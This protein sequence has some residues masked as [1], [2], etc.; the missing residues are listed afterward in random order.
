MEK[1]RLDKWLWACRFYKSRT[2]ASEACKN[3]KIS[4]RSIPL[5]AAHFVSVGDLLEIRKNGFQFL[6]LIQKIIEKRVGA[7]IAAA[8][9]VN[10]TSEEELNKYQ[11]WFTGKAQAEKRERGAG[12]PTKRER[13]EIDDF[14]TLVFDEFDE[15]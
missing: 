12:R 15:I 9:Y 13:R 7:P 6:I 1:T 2:L 14:K 5:K 8:C 11:S 4:S 3:G 10:K